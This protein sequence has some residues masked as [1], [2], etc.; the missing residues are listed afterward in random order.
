LFSATR[1]I[2]ARRPEN[3]QGC[4]R[5]NNRAI[6]IVLVEPGLGLRGGFDYGAPP[7]VS[8]QGRSPG[9]RGESQLSAPWRAPD[10]AAERPAPNSE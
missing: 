9:E 1:K 7:F 8:A 6:G 10:E 2:P 4:T 3:P 5:K